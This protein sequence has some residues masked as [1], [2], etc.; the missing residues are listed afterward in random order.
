MTLA[1]IWELMFRYLV[2][3]VGLMAARQQSCCQLRYNLKQKY[4]S[5]IKVR[6]HLQHISYKISAHQSK[7][8]YRSRILIR[9]NHMRCRSRRSMEV[10]W[11]GGKIEKT[12]I[13]N[14]V[15][16]KKFRKSEDEQEIIC[17]G[18]MTVKVFSKM[19]YEIKGEIEEVTL[20][21]VTFIKKRFH[22]L[23]NLLWLIGVSQIYS[24]I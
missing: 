8:I 6:K 4:C 24:T 9:A 17:D 7:L 12:D 3:S 1:R 14:W 11:E 15:R 21:C 16:M 23:L 10:C 19:E 2:V 13:R 20:L 22:I 5:S 18:I